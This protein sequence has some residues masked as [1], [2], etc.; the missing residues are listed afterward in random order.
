[1]A[2]RKNQLFGRK[3]QIVSGM[4]QNPSLH[5]RFLAVDMS[6]HQNT[7]A[8]DCYAFFYHFIDEMLHFTFFI[9]V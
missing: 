3:F 4:R 2:A 9:F 7:K 1:M 5:E 8:T 6:E